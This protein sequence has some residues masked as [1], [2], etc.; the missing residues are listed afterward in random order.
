[1]PVGPDW[2]HSFDT[3]TVTVSGTGT[4]AGAGVVRLTLARPAR[5]NAV[6]RQLADDLADAVA[7]AEAR[8]ARVGV[9]DGEGT[10]FCSGADLAEL[11]T[12]G[13]SLERV[14]ESLTGGTI[15]W[16]AAVRGAARGGA[17]SILS[18]CPRVVATPSASFSLPELGSGSFPAEVIGRQEELLGSRR[19]F[20]LALS[21]EVIDAAA[22]RELGLVTTVVDDGALEEWL[23]VA[24]ARLSAFD[25]AGL[26]EGVALWN[27][28]VRSVGDA[29]MPAT[30]TPAASLPATSTPATSQMRTR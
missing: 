21:A 12:A 14:V 20:E 25:P 28:Y 2:R 19:A 7:L 6:N 13:R 24:S 26:R 23:A 1:M 8:G 16:T 18:A 4:S 3:V 29:R 30:S 5:R 10:A 27:A 17:L 11:E 9:L 15:H 22:A